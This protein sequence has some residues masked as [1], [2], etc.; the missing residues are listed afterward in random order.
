MTACAVSPGST[1]TRML[2]ATAAIYDLADVDEFAS[3][4]LIRRLLEPSEVAAT[5]ALCCS[6]EGAA[7]NGSVVSVDGG[8]GR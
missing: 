8:F 5:I 3:S 2:D 1:R 6:V 4:Q 7:L